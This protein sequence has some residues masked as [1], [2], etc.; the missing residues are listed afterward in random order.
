MAGKFLPRPFGSDILGRVPLTLTPHPDFPCAA[1]RSI[2]VEVTRPGPTTLVFAYR[3]AGRIADL[4]LAPPAA[5]LFTDGL[6]RTTCFEA[7]LKPEDGEGY[8]EL[9]FAPSSEWA[10]YGFGGY[11]EG[12]TPLQIATPRIAALRGDAAFALDVAIDLEGLPPPDPCRLALSAVIE[13]ASGAK[14]YWALAHPEGRPDFHHDAG[15]AAMLQGPPIKT[16]S[17][18]SSRRPAQRSRPG[19]TSL[20]RAK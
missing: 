17:K 19:S 11:R 12:M 8:V 16:Q 10:A 14:S 3:A 18:L 6:W 20:D 15:F 2:E 7:F 9:N 4:A 5:P 13:A 1:L